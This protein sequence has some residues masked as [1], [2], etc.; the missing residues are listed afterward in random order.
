MK[1]DGLSFERINSS[2]RVQSCAVI[3]STRLKQR[4]PES[5]GKVIG[6]GGSFGYGA[7]M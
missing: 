1:V 5:I 2:E 4:Y 6:Y 3:G 7:Q